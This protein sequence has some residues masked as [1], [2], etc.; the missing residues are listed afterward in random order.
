M[1]ISYQTVFEVRTKK[2]KW[3]SGKEQE[4][5]KTMKLRSVAVGDT[6]TPFFLI[7]VNG[8]ENRW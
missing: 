8:K 6:D 3:S 2:E 5:K 1:C 4:Q 7:I